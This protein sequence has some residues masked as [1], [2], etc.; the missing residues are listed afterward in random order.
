MILA[1]AL[2]VLEIISGMKRVCGICSHKI[3]QHASYLK[4]L[5][6]ARR[7]RVVECW[8]PSDSPPRDDTTAVTQKEELVKTPREDGGISWIGDAPQFPDVSM[9]AWLDSPMEMGRGYRGVGKMVDEL[10]PLSKPPPTLPQVKAVPKNFTDSRFNVEPKVMGL[11]EKENVIPSPQGT[12][13]PKS[14]AELC[15]C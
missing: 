11:Q 4:E 6:F 13:M 15:A 14:K 12:H 3:K 8:H 1:L 7:V 5:V 9:L 2:A 10:E